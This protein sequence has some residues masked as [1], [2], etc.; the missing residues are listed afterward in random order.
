MN[1][2]ILSQP[3]L[4]THNFLVAYDVYKE[5]LAASSCLVNDIP[6]RGSIVRTEIIKFKKIVQG[7]L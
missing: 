4:Y 2:T 7:G 1:S 6:Y 5:Q 3:T